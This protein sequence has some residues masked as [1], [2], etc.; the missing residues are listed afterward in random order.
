[1]ERKLVVLLY[2]KATLSADSDVNNSCRTGK[3]FY[4]ATLYSCGFE[5]QFLID[6]EISIK[7]FHTTAPLETITQTAPSNGFTGETGDDEERLG[8]KLLIRVTSKL[9]YSTLK[10]WQPNLHMKILYHK[11]KRNSKKF[12]LL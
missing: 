12:F 1:M 3:R 4:L 9:L 5:K 8:K 10:K 6:T 7:K 2:P 11:T